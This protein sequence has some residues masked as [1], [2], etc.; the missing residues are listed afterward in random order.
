M[1]QRPSAFLPLRHVDFRNF[2]AASQVSNFGG[3]VQGVAAAWLM[4]GLTTSPSMI[5][6]VQASTSLPIMIFSL[7]S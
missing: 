4:T 5:A 6:L 1:T 2:W 3:L 7:S